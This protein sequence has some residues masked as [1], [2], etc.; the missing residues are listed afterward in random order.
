ME[1]ED[2][3][4]VCRD[5][6]VQFTWTKGEQEFF[7]SKGFTNSPTRCPECRK[8]NRS[9]KKDDKRSQSSPA[10]E[11]NVQIKCKACGKIST[12]NFQPKNPNDLLCAECFEKQL[13]SNTG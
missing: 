13:Q 4:L 12:V 8:K 5:C 1:Y 7:A 2:K 10:P 3:K 6:G 9:G 11:A